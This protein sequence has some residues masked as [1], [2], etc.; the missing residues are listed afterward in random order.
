[1]TSSTAP[2]AVVHS[3]AAFALRMRDERL[4]QH[5][6]GGRDP[7]GQPDSLQGRE[8]RRL[9]CVAC[10]APVTTAAQY[11]E[12]A[13]RHEHVCSNPDG[14]VFRI[15]CF[16]AAPGCVM[17]GRPTSRWTWF[18]GYRWQVALC[19]QCGAHLGWRFRDGSGGGFFGLIVP[20]L[21]DCDARRRH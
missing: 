4:P 1:M 12:Q 17:I 6:H 19:G 3:G 2:A 7:H 14:L 18:P 8:E 20:R 11:S 10:G 9:C 15:R 16:A 21:M 13:G 5:P